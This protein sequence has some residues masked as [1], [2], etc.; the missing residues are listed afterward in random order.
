M[1]HCERVADRHVRNL[2]VDF[3]SP[4]EELLFLTAFVR[5]GPDG[6][7]ACKGA[8]V[9]GGLRWGAKFPSDSAEGGSTIARGICKRPHPVSGPSAEFI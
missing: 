5:P 8:T 7:D 4:D 9:G 6:P 2:A 3:K 1:A